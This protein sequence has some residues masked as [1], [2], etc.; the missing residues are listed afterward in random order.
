MQPGQLTQVRRYL[1]FILLLIL[2]A[3][4]PSFQGGFVWDDDH[5]IVHGRLI[6]SLR[7][8]PTLFTHDSCYNS[9]GEAY[10]QTHSALTYRP[11]PLASFFVDH[12][13]YGLH[14]AGYHLTSLLLH[15]ANAVL[16]V[17]LGMELGLSAAA[18]A[19]A[20]TLFGIHPAW[21]EAVYWINGRSDPIFMAF[22]LGAVLTWLRHRRD[23]GGIALG[24][25]AVVAG[26]MFGAAISKETSFVLALS[27]AA[28]FRSRA[29][30]LRGLVEEALPFAL[31]LGAAVGVRMM[32][33]HGAAVTRSPSTV[34]YVLARLPMFLLDALQSLVLPRSTVVASLMDRYRVIHPATTALA[35]ALVVLGAAG[36]LWRRT[37]AGSPRELWFL[38]AFV[39]ALL[40]VSLLISIP[41]WSGWGRY[42][43]PVGPMFSLA[44]V[45]A[46]AESTALQAQLS[47]RLRR[48]LLGAGALALCTLTISASTPWHSQ[49]DFALSLVEDQPDSSMGYAWV[50]IEELKAHHALTAFRLLD[51]SVTMNPR[52]AFAWTNRAE[53]L[54]LLGRPE[55]AFESAHRALALDPTETA[56][57]MLLGYESARTRP[58]VAARYL[59]QAIAS[60]PYSPQMAQ[61]A[62][63]LLALG[64]APMRAAV[65][66]L[67]AT[68]R[69][70]PLGPSLGPILRAAGEPPSR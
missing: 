15:M 20:G 59:L 67:L 49:R 1:P 29:R 38:S 39:L 63:S 13:F 51:R 45:G 65:E 5:V 10:A 36:A 16:V 3:Y 22:Y 54:M 6:G 23:E 44:L 62:R 50:G 17:F 57:M 28:L 9:Y 40:P 52:V 24:R 19:A 14:P 27:T 32:V 69:Y 34:G 42:L 31:G 33:L 25:G 61:N 26:L 2:V 55:E 18:A 35:L 58:A 30:G 64:G 48:V 70:A 12:F 60:N 53:A 7:N 56:A 66:A 4:A 47:E 11:I 68:P 8:V 21:A 41:T 37:R 43:Y 46:L